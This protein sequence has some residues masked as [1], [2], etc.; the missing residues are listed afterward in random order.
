MGFSSARQV[1]ISQYIGANQR[2]K[3]R[4]CIM[5]R[6]KILNWMNVPAEAFKQAL[7][8]FTVCMTGLV[9]IYGYNI[10]SAVLLFFGSASRAGMNALIN[11]S[12]KLQ[13]QFCHSDFGR[14]CDGNRSGILLFWF[15][16][17]WTDCKS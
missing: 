7:G 10:V 14:H 8:Q 13:A 3:S 17:T 15:L 9:F 4:I 5:L 11:G 1:V 12:G 6:S 16:E 2:E